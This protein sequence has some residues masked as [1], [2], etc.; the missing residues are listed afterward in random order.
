M[1]EEEERALGTPLTPNNI[2]RQNFPGHSTIP[3]S[4]H[5]QNPLD[6]RPSGGLFYFVKLPGILVFGMA[7]G[8]LIGRCRFSILLL[9]PLAH[10]IYYFFKRRADKFAL[11]Y[12]TLLRE[13]D[14]R[15]TIHEYET[16]EWLNFIVQ[17]FWEVSE[18]RVSSEIYSAVN[19]E[20]KANTPKILK[21]L[22][23]T[24]LTLGTRPPVIERIGFLNKIEDAITIEFAMNFIPMQTSE[25][26][27]QYFG[28]EK[29][30]WNT[31]IELTA[32]IGFI[33][34][35]I[36]VRNF[37]F[38]GLFRAEISLI[39]EIPFIK[40]FNL[41]MLELP[42]IDFELHPL[43]AVDFMDLPYLSNAI[44]SIINSQ[45]K[46]HLL[47]PKC[48]SI[49]LQNIAEYRG[50]VI[51]VVYVY[52]G[53]LETKEE[54]P[55]FIE[56]TTD[57]RDHARTAQKTGV[58]PIFNEGFYRIVK[59]TTKHIGI[60][61][62]QNEERAHGKVLLRNLNKYYYNE[63]VNLASE[64]MRKR[65]EVSTRFF[66]ITEK[67][68]NSGIVS[69]SLVS[70]NDLQ[71]LGDPQN[72]VYSTYCQISLETK[73]SLRARSVINTF[74]SKR[75]FST[76]D[77]YYNESFTFFVRE[78]DNYIFKLSVMDEKTDKVIGTLV[79]PAS[80][81]NELACNRYHLSG[82]EN[83]S[84]E[85]RFGVSYISM[86]EDELEEPEVEDD[87]VEEESSAEETENDEVVVSTRDGPGVTVDGELEGDEEAILTNRKY[88]SIPGT[89]M[90]RP[91][92][93][94]PRIKVKTP[95]KPKHKPIE[96][97]GIGIYNKKGV[98]NSPVIFESAYRFQIEEI[99]ER[100]SFYMVF[101]TDYL[102]CRME[103]FSTDLKIS[104]Y[105]IVPIKDEKIIRV[106]LFRMLISGDILVSEEYFDVGDTVVLFD[107]V[108][109]SLSTTIKPFTQCAAQDTT[110]NMKI[111]QFRMD[112]FSYDSDYSL[113]VS[114]GE[115]GMH[116]KLPGMNTVMVG[117]EEVGCLLR[118][119]GQRKYRFKLPLRTMKES[120]SPGENLSCMLTCSVQSCGFKMPV[121]LSSG[122]LEIY[123]IRASNVRSVSDGKSSPYVKVYLNNEKIFK[124]DKKIRNSDPIF[125]E[126]LRI[127]VN[128][129]TDVIGFYIYEYNAIAT[130]TVICYREISLLNV[131]EGYS[132][133]NIEMNDGGDDS[134]TETTL[135]VI[136]NYSDAGDTT[137]TYKEWKN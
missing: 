96:S 53:R 64:Q 33:S 43:K 127:A 90:G 49:D 130:S 117:S 9:L 32:T 94:K 21:S 16:V 52:V 56:I 132:K 61:A 29:K 82:V 55:V 34:L 31:C 2:P 40:S 136:F 65:L 54:K 95:K 109:V 106:R 89:F 128:K 122:K 103:P 84:A 126:S 125:N 104:R 18:A 38:S 51:G 19:R 111:V 81:A 137:N 20:L 11:T 27:L 92:P 79:L 67:K 63:Q 15:D 48:I 59:D 121:W 75:I 100:G 99:S 97:L 47:F 112:E 4:R 105:V 129:N 88:K 57:G 86:A 73:E 13:K 17:K 93:R 58:C 118:G 50:D 119:E 62:H 70:V 68:T 91:K 8:Y 101:E 116:N 115:V 46:N 60:T 28:E 39:R 41:C 131:N 113:D 14:R 135:Q 74:E 107:T 78:I 110:E 102:N 114:T 76:K 36:L 30:H 124:T 12:Q 7:L 24:E 10:I 25:D 72:R 98:C 6:F 123:I 80:C 5:I 22:K 133:F 66:R 45:L 134:R 71:A 69:L 83:G 23:L 3:R 44:S 26:I 108:R 120:F 1:A 35:P 37:T 87:E 85:I 42:L 77:A